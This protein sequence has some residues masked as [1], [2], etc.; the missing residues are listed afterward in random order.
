MAIKLCAKMVISSSGVGQSKL[1]YSDS[2]ICL[3][4]CKALSSL[5]IAMSL[6]LGRSSWKRS[7][8]GCLAFKVADAAVAPSMHQYEAWS[9]R[10]S[11]TEKEAMDGHQG[12]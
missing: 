2:K 9:I 12:E 5:M 4:L 8:L 6:S 3:L 11:L 1:E 7:V 10:G